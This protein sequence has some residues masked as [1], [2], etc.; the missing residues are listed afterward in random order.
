MRLLQLSDPH[1]LADPGAHVRGRRPEH[2]L[3]HGLT[4]A[5]DQ[6]AASGERADLLLISGDLCQDESAGGYERLRTV[7]ADLALPVALVAGNHD[8]PLRLRAGLGLRAHLGPAR[9]AVGQ[10]Q[11]LLLESH[12]AGSCAGRLG[13]RQLAWLAQELTDLTGPAVVALH[14]PPMAIGDPA[15]DAIALEDGA[16]LLALLAPQ[17]RVRAVLCGH[18]HQHWQGWV[19][20]RPDLP[21]WACPSTLCGFGPVQPCPLDRPQDPG[22]R[23]LV[24]ERGGEIRQ[25]LLRWDPPSVEA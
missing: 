20:G 22:G 23:W 4:A 5:L 15:M 17:P 14:H 1:L 10:G 24:L 13:Q 9:L 12:R 21:V 8:H 16:E 7:L 2:W 3:R 6:L 19:P 18:L 11:L 25:R